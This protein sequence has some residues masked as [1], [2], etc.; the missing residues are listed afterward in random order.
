MKR[1][2]AFADSYISLITIIQIRKYLFQNDKFDIVLSDLTSGL[3][4][5][6]EKKTLE[7]LFD[8]V[9]F[10]SYEKMTRFDKFRILFSQKKMIHRILGEELPFYT[11]IF[12]WNPSL[13]F[14]S[15]WIYLSKSKNMY[16]LHLYGEALGAY[17][18]DCP[19][20]DGVFK[21][22]VLN[23]YLRLVFGCIPVKEMIYDYYVFEPS[24]ISFESN[25]S[26]V[27][28]PKIVTSDI[29]YLNRVFEYD[30]NAAVIKE[31]VLFMDKKHADE[32]SDEIKIV[33]LL[34]KMNALLGKESFAVKAHPRQNKSIYR[35]NGIKLISMDYPWEIYCMNNSI[36]D[37]TIISYSSSAMYMPYILMDSNHKSIC[38]KIDTIF[39]QTFSKEYD[40]F[41][42]KVKALNKNV[43]VINDISELSRLVDEENQK[44]K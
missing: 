34:R 14:Y 39:T 40:T 24:L 36:D 21:N 44:C 31:K 23:E 33:G 20:E 1:V 7:N 17:V 18:T 10:A 43:K 5:I 11:D 13:L 2:V 35:D 4:T 37:K 38:I 9:Y 30:L 26:V 16:R 6:F 28:I 22:R 27:G 29:S 32:T 25:R 12:F 19:V 42:K 8:R 15:Y 41:I 3:K